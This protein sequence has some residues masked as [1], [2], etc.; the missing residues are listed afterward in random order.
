MK[1]GELLRGTDVRT[2]TPELEITGIASDSR[3]VRPGFLFLCLRGTRYDG[4][5]Y[6]AQ[7]AEKGAVCVIGEEAVGGVKNMLLT[8]SS[9]IT[10]SFLWH[11]FTGRPLEG[12]GMAKVAVTGT[13]GKTS[14]VFTLRHILRSAGRRVGVITT[15]SALAGDDPISLGEHG[16]SSVSD[17][18]GAMTTPDPEY[19]F[20]AAAEMKARGCDVL[21]YEASSQ[22]LTLH[23]T[24]AVTPDIAVFTNLSSEHLDCHGTMENYF[25]AKARLMESAKLGIVNVDDP[26]MR[27]LPMMFPGKPILTC[28]QEPANVADTDICALRYRSLGADGVEYVYF[29]DEAVFRIRTPQIG[30]H[31]VFNTMQAAAC[32]IRLGVDPLTVKEA[33]ACM[34]GVDGRLCRVTFSEPEDA[35]FPAEVFIDYAHTP[36]ALEAALST[37]AEIKR[38]RLIVLFGCGG[39]R[40]RTK[41]PKMAEAAQKHA[42]FTIVTSDNPRTEDP[43]RILDEIVRGLDC[44]KPHAVIHDRR[45][46]I[47]YA[48]NEAGEGDL[49][50]LAGKGHEKYEITTDGKHPF[51]EE[52][53]VREAVHDRC[54]GKRSKS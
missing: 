44:A 36:D 21:I 41:R 34:N 6:A 1:L 32:A 53:I 38:G 46:A 45:E 50:L 51:D 25:A 33:L 47:R 23:K 24:D 29:S 16:G 20:G 9:R 31:S 2:D 13:A 27:R 43:A 10:E 28:S 3:R 17:L 14:V 49:I 18:A 48:V 7:A 19:F 40:D 5:A 15:I 39:D 22:S 54:S 8:R 42:D 11:N 26:Y 52:Q 35:A 12:D 30:R 37:L 4:H